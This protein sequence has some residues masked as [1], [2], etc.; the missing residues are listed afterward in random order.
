VKVALEVDGYRWHAERSRFEAGPPRQNAFVEDEWSLFR[1]T[2]R[3]LARDLDAAIAP[4]LRTL[5]RR[6]MQTASSLIGSTTS[7]GPRHGTEE[8]K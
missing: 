3:A 2:A 4:L 7:P 5:E 6:R 1:V 8:E